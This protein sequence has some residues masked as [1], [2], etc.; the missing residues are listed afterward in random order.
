VK[1][2]V[3]GAKNA[4]KNTPFFHKKALRLTLESQKMCDKNA[5][6]KNVIKTMAYFFTF[7]FEMKFVSA[8]NIMKE[9][10]SIIYA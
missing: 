10:E 3:L 2:R 6:S 8:E 4:P 7:H 1:N 9:V 5:D